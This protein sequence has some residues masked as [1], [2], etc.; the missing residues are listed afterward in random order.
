M[1]IIKNFAAALTVALL[2]AANGALAAGQQSYYTGEKI[3]GY[4]KGSF[5]ILC[6]DDVNFRVSA[7]T[8]RVLKVLPH[9]SLE[10]RA[11]E[12]RSRKAVVN[13]EFNIGKAVFF[14]IFSENFLLM[15]DTVAISDKVVVFG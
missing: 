12:I 4:D 1:Q 8:G 10:V 2:V 6:G 5:V 9:H 11:V 15:N 14:R 13:V 7:E 3:K